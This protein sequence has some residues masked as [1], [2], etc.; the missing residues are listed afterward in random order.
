MVRR[1]DE[2]HSL[3]AL[4][5]EF[6]TDMQVGIISRLSVQAQVATVSVVGGPRKDGGSIVPKAFAAL[7]QHGTRVISVAQAASEY[8][9]TFAVPEEEV[10]GV[11]AFIHRELALGANGDVEH[12]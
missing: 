9:V 2:A 1:E 4:R 5:R 12:G 10:D 8:N 3:R 11:V 6:E 7:G